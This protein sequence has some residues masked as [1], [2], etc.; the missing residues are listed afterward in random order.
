MWHDRVRGRHVHLTAMF[1]QG[2]DRQLVQLRICQPSCTVHIE[3]TSCAIHMHTHMDAGVHYAMCIWNCG[4]SQVASLQTRYDDKYED[5]ESD[6]FLDY[7][8][9]TRTGCTWQGS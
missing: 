3:Q 4:D 9:Y 2:I 8:G 7:Y 6:L 5:S 1:D